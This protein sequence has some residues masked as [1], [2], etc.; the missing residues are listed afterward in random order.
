MSSDQIVAF[1]LLCGMLLGS[2]RP[3]LAIVLAGSL[4]VLLDHN[5]LKRQQQQQQQQHCVPPV[6][7][8]D[9]CTNQDKASSNCNLT[10]TSKSLFDHQMSRTDCR[11]RPVISAP[12]DCDHRPHTEAAVDRAEATSDF[13]TYLLPESQQLPLVY[14]FTNT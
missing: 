5:K 7:H 12:L 14:S 4:L 8:I 13:Y 9:L 11:V 2:G 6:Q 10:L 3:G 1:T